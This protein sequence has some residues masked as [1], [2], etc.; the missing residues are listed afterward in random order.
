[1][2]YVEA[3]APAAICLTLMV[4]DLRRRR[5]LGT[6]STDWS[7]VHNRRAM[8]LGAAVAV[9]LLS[10]SLGSSLAD[11]AFAVPT[12]MFVRALAAMAANRYGPL[13]QHRGGAPR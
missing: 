8:M 5:R 3:F 12:S 1:M 10:S 6:T 9:L 7:F 2:K 11:I 4:G 13:R